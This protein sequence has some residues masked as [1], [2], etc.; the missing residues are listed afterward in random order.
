M[1]SLGEEEPHAEPDPQ[2][3]EP[4]R[5]GVCLSGGGFRAAFYSLGALRYLAEAGI[6]RQVEVISAVSGGSIAAA[7]VADRWDR[8]EQQG[9]TID[10]FLTEIDA[11]FR[12]VVTTRN[13]RN[14]WVGRSLVDEARLHPRGRGVALGQTLAADL[15]EHDRVAQLPGSGPQ[16]I[17]TATELTSGRAFRISRDFTGNFD[18]GYLEPAPDALQLGTAVAASAAFPMSLSVVWLPTQGLGFRD[19]PPTLSLVDGGVYDNLGLEWFQRSNPRRPKSG[20]QANFLIVV[21]ASGELTRKDRTYGP[22][23][24][25]TRDL[26]VQYAQT[27]NTRVGWLID[28]FEAS[29][30]RGVYIG[31]GR[32]PRQP[33]IE[34][35]GL[36]AA[37]SGA[38]PS[39]LVKPLA[40][41]RTDLDRFLPEEAELLSYQ[42]Y[43]SLHT[44]VATWAPELALSAPAWR[45]PKYADMSAADLDRVLKLLADGARLKARR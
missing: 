9:G 14:R 16:V 21:N 4:L 38:L 45:L 18:Y 13:L 24:A 10:A 34:E 2:A 17:F 32:D 1:N 6:L 39:A 44:R 27:L 26:S 22:I 12:Q 23:R 11:P 30:A 5:I 33:A 8:F 29:S 43:W 3:D 37:S 19:P 35:E 20:R 25:F 15:Y 36:E 28:E 41:L 7:M 42:A 31:T 40:R